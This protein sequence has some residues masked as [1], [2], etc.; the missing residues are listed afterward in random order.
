MLWL[1][2]CRGGSKRLP[3]KNVRMFCG[4]PLWMWSIA[5]ACRIASDEDIIIA[6][7]DIPSI[8]ETPWGMQRSADLCRDDTPTMAVIDDVWSK[9][10][11]HDA[12][13]LLQPTSPTRRDGLVREM[14]TRGDACRSTTN[15]T[16]N[17]QCWVFRKGMEMVNVETFPGDDIDTEEDF[18]AAERKMMERF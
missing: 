11:A 3:G 4:L 13:T 6:S 15:G 2:P 9:F 5:T 10:P 16:E 7:S 8:L 18:L 12:L 1:V 14:A 17:G